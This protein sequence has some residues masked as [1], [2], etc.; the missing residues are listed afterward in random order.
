MIDWP[1]ATVAFVLGFLV[2]VPLWLLDRRREKR[3]RRSQAESEWTR[4]AVR[5][6]ATATQEN[7]TDVDVLRVIAEYPT[8]RW[9]AILG[10]ADFEILERLQLAFMI[11][12]VQPHKDSTHEAVEE[13]KRQATVDMLDLALR[14]TTEEAAAVRRAEQRVRKACHPIRKVRR[15]LKARPQEPRHEVPS[16][17]PAV[18]E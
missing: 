9:R 17:G 13:S 12:T 11:P 14:R 15:W 5:I 4:A 8:E 7:V 6:V 3:E 1:N 10:S 16:E 18:G 2:A